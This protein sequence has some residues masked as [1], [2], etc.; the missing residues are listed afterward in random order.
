MLVVGVIVLFGVGVAWF[1]GFGGLLCGFGFCG[2][3]SVV[4]G[5]AAL[6]GFGVGFWVGF[7]W[8][9]II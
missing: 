5:L 1:S 4:S 6:L 8:V 7:G 2:G 9:G 3:A